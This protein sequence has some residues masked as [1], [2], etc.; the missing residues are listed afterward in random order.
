[1]SDQ[2]ID[3]H[4]QPFAHLPSVHLNMH[5][6]K[7][8]TAVSF[9]DPILAQVIVGVNPDPAKMLLDEGMRSREMTGL[10]DIAIPHRCNH[11]AIFL[12]TFSSTSWWC[13]RVH[14]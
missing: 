4:V 5:V 2:V 13:D 6:G 9:R 10:A 11:V 1:M 8:S 14:P 12:M 7:K 3:L